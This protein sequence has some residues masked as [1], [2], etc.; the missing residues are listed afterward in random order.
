MCFA[1]LWG[2]LSFYFLSL[3]KMFKKKKGKVKGEKG[4]RE[5]FPVSGI[6]G[7]T[8]GGYLHGGEGG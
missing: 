6:G 1:C 8:G 2:Y 4:S 5:N 7:G 3:K